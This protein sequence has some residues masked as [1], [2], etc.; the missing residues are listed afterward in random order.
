MLLALKRRPSNVKAGFYYVWNLGIS[1]HQH[2]ILK[3]VRSPAEID[4]AGISYAKA[5]QHGFPLLCT[6]RR[7]D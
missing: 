2:R 1:C 4:L 3:E 7:V 6:S 5:S